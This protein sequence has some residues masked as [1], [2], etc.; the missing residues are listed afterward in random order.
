ME[1]VKGME[2]PL[3]EQESLKELFRFLDEN[4]MVRE[5]EQ[6]AQMADYIDVM[7]KQM[8]A[9]MS[10]L[11]GIRRQLSG[12]EDRGIRIK[13]EKVAAA[14]VIKVQETG[15]DLKE[16]KT[17]FLRRIDQLA[18]AGKTRGR[19]AVS[20]VLGTV[21]FP[22]VT[23]R[24]QHLLRGTIH[25]ADCAID[26]LGMMGDEL[27]AAKQHLGN[28]G[29]ALTGKKLKTPAARDVEKGTFY[30][31]QRI[32]F[33][34]METLARME[35]KTEKLLERMDH[36]ETADTKEKTSV[37]DTLQELRSDPISTE[38]SVQRKRT[39]PVRE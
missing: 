19:E 24:L 17:K 35:K 30:E 16:L 37:R 6:V 4:G 23:M 25:A 32:L 39:R 5:K 31:A 8:G 14:V 34:S 9:V 3:R 29:R 18:E 15:D 36:L 21:R 12:I 10:E 2:I 28:T 33:Q 11:Q 20:A 38:T 22:Q 1:D 27:H 13:A 26:R 7:E